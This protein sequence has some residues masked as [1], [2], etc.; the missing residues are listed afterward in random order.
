MSKEI[1]SIRQ[2]TPGQHTPRP[3]QAKGNRGRGEGSIYFRESKGLWVGSVMVGRKPDGKVDRRVVYGKTRVE[4]R[5]KLDDIRRR[6]EEGA[7]ADADRAGAT[8]RAFLHRWLEAIRANVRPSTWQR[9]AHSV[10]H[11]LVPALGRTRLTALRP[12]AVQKLYA[13][14]LT[15]GLAPRSVHHIH[16]ILHTAL[17]QAVKWGYVSHNV[18][19]AVDPPAVPRYEMHFLTP[20]QV[21]TLF[22]ASRG[23]RLEALWTVAVFTGCREGELLGMEWEDIDWEAG[24]VFVRRTLVGTKGSVPAFAEP[25]TARGRRVIPLPEEAVTALRAHRARQ[26]AERLALG[27]DYADYG[28]IFPT[29]LGTPLRARNVVRDFKALLSRAGLPPEVRVHDLRHTAA[30]LLLSEG[31]DVATAAAILGHAQPSTTLNVY[32]HAIPSNLRTAVQ[33][34]GGAIR[35]GRSRIAGEPGPASES[36]P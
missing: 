14:K 29:H 33:R 5:R 23:D 1:D 2:P 27:P 24:T 31:T 8:L 30:A 22:D 20:E 35:R 11:D 25:K 3:G 26:N 17:R 34:L 12:E 10:H 7:L 9:Y 16:T 21:A 28:L 18:T 6:V 13:D 19:E 32:G 4:A 15:S 36:A